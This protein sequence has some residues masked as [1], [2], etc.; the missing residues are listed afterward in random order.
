VRQESFPL[1]RAFWEEHGLRCGFCTPGFLM[2]A[3]RFLRDHPHLT[4]EEIRRAL[5]GNICRCTGYQ[6]IIRAVERAAVELDSASDSARSAP[7]GK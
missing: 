2:T 1:Q 5:V 6:F 4:R 7:A 3:E